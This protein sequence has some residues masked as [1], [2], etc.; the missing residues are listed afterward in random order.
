M[1]EIADQLFHI[2]VMITILGFGLFGF[3]ATTGSFDSWKNRE[4]QKKR[5][6]TVKRRIIRLGKFNASYPPVPFKNNIPAY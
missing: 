4:G 3:M 5:T 6:N 1:R 2:F